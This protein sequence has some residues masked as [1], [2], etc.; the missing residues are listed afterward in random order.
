VRLG[1]R[2]AASGTPTG[3]GDLE[4]YFRTNRGRLIHKWLHYFEV[5]E[6]HFSA[7][8]GT[9]PTIV[10][11]GVYHGGSLEM[12]RDYFGPG[13]RVVGVDHDPRTMFEAPQIEVRVGDQ[14]DR[15][16]LAELAAD[17]GPVQVVIDDGGH[18]MPQ[19]IATFEELW[20]AV[21]EGGVFL[22]EDVHTSY[23]PVYQ[24][25]AHRPGTF[26]Q[27]VKGLVDDINAWDAKDAVPITPYSHTIRGLHVY[28]KIVVFDKGRMGPPRHAMTGTPAFDDPVV[29][30]HLLPPEG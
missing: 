17:L 28:D 15:A 23:D 29:V 16:F 19:Q 9:S 12:W 14:L 11:F 26:I 22:T 4:R 30:E 13:A 24:G 20:P 21:A 2:G 6:R 7:Y 27:Y 1:R 25:G 5:Y 10:E 8:R 18:H 3:P